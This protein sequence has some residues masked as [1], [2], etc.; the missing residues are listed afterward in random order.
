MYSQ[1]K[2]KITDFENRRSFKSIWLNSQF[3]EEVRHSKPPQ[4][5]LHKE[6]CFCDSTIDMKLFLV[7]QEITL[8]PDKHGC[9]RDLLEECKKAVE[10]SENGSEKL[11]YPSVFGLLVFLSV[12]AIRTFWQLLQLFCRTG[13]LHLMVNWVQIKKSS[14]LWSVLAF[15]TLSLTLGKSLEIECLLLWPR[16]S[17]VKFIALVFHSSWSR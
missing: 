7:L 14:T 17:V 6:K 2:M 5:A 8:Y 11:R 15:W 1:L 13:S 3:R 12:V 16:L 10:L 9:V 4:K